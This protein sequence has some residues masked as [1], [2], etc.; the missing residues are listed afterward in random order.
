MGFFLV[1][2]LDGGKWGIWGK[3]C[4]CISGEVSQFIRVMGTRSP[5]APLHAF[6]GGITVIQSCACYLLPLV[7]PAPLPCP[8]PPSGPGGKK[9]IQMMQHKCGRDRVGAGTQC[10]FWHLR[11]SGGAWNEGQPTWE[12]GQV[13]RS[14]SSMAPHATGSMPPAGERGGLMPHTVDTWYHG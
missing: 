9:K 11:F 8:W 7:L 3:C 6:W 2:G 14:S 1:L 13:R 5:L 10:S 12:G 4:G